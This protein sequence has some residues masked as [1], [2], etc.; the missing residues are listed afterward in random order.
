M[1]EAL[2]KGLPAARRAEITVSEPRA[3]RREFLI[4]TY[5]VKAVEKN[6]DAIKGASLILLA[7]KPQQMEDV[8]NEL[9]PEI[10]PD[11]TVVS[12]AAGITLS[13]Y[14][15]RLKTK[16]IV[17]V[18]P[19][20]AA[21]AQESMSV[22]SLCECF[23]DED[24]RPVKDIFMSSGRA[25]VL[26]EKHMDAVTALSGSGPAFIALFV[27]AM[28]EAAKGMALGADDARTLA[29]QTLRGTAA[30]LDE[31][32]EPQR[33]IEMVRSPGGTTAEGLKVFDARE[34]ESIVKEALEAAAR[35]SKELAR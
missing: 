2:I 35:R 31:G 23:P 28:I 13:Y 32:L 20:V 1:A 26:P 29:I 6:L 24:M 22:L 10:G 27:G 18:M 3:E 34:L 25:L 9:A 30:L 21:M 14:Q 4:K 15:Q 8:L 5:G 17:R 33:L 12:I 19:N 7:V 16:K 11:H